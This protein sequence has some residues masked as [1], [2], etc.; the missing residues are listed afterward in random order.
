MAAN[1]ELRTARD[2]HGDSTL[3]LMVV[4]VV[5]VVVVVVAAV[6]FRA[7]SKQSNPS[8]LDPIDEDTVEA[9]VK[10]LERVRNGAVVQLAMRS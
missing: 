9:S 10:E 2:R 1:D 7:N 3:A 5:A 8:Y 6:L 4:A